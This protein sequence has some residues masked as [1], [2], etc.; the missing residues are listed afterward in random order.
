MVNDVVMTYIEKNERKF[1]MKDILAKI[2]SK[3]YSKEDFDEALDVLKKKEIVLDK[4]VELKQKVGFR[5]PV[6]RKKGGL[7]W[8]KIAGIIGMVFFVLMFLNFVL[9]VLV[10]VDVSNSIGG[11]IMLGLLAVL[12]VLTCFYFYGF[13]RMGKSVDSKL[14]RGAAIMNIVSV[15]LFVAL[16]VFMIIITWM[17]FSTIS[18]GLSDGVGFGGNF[19]TWAYLFYL[20]GVVTLVSVF[21]SRVLFSISLIRVRKKVGF[22]LIAGVLG[23]IVA[24]LLLVLYGISI[25]LAMNPFGFLV[26][27]D[28][29][30]EYLAMGFG[31]LSMIMILFE[32]LSLFNSSKKFE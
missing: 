23:L 18:S 24:V 16:M 19:E 9:G 2:L 11:W 25:Y 3:G 15:L 14:L 5:E 7:K 6:S 4:D 22:L 31:V 30:I 8:M 1:P 21:V 20:F 29:F 26:S 12:I 28:S 17:M 27:I 32:S 13:I 10:G